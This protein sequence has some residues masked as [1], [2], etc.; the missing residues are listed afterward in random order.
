[1]TPAADAAARREALAPDRSFIVQ[2]PAGS[3][4]TELLTQRYLR[5]LAAVDA[6]E[7]ILAITFTRKAAGEM[8]DRVLRALAAADEAEPDEPH[9][10]RTWQLARAVRERDRERD[11]RL[12]E[13]PARLNIDTLDAYA[14]GLTR[15]LPLTAG[16]GV[17]PRITERAHDV[18]V[19][20]AR[21]T[22]AAL[23]E[24]NGWSDAVAALLAHLDNDAGQLQGLLVAML[25]KR[26]QWLRLIA[27]GH[28]REV[29][30]AALA[31]EVEGQL[32]ALCA[33]VPPAL[34]DDLIMLARRAA[35]NLVH[36]GGDGAQC[37]C[38]ELAELPGAAADDVLLWRGLAA[39]WQTQSGWRKRLTKNEGFPPDQKDFKQQATGL[40]LELGNHPEFA[41]RLASVRSLPPVIYDDAQWLILDALID[42]LKLAAAQLQVVFGEQGSVDFIEIA[43]RALRALGEPDAPTDLALAL[44]YRLQHILV[45]EFQDTSWSQYALLERLT[46]GWSPGDGRTLFLVGDP[47][48]S[49]YRFREAEVGLYL[50]ARREGIGDVHLT[51]LTLGINFRSTAPVVDWINAAFAT[52]F[53]E[54]EDVAAGA[55]PY[56]PAI[57]RDEDARDGGVEVVARLDADDIDEAARV[58]TLIEERRTAAP[59]ETIAV[60]ARSRGQVAATMAALRAAGLKAQAVELEHLA[61]RP[62]VQDL[63][64]LTR[65]LAHP[66]DRLAWLA[67]LRAPWCGLTLADLAA[68]T[69]ND[70]RCIWDLLN[71]GERRGALAVDGRTRLERVAAALAPAVDNWR[72]QPLRRLVEQTWVALSG[73]AC[74]AGPADLDNAEAFFSLLE[75]IDEAGDL[76][77]AG[78]LAERLADLYARPAPD[79]D[80]RLQ[81]MTIHKAKGLEFDTVILPALERL[82]RSDQRQLLLWLERPRAGREPDFLLAPIAAAEAS[83]D[84]LYD[85]LK[86]LRDRQDEL[87]QLRLLYVA[88]TRA[89]RH[90]YLL[91]NIRTRAERNGREIVPP[92]SRSLLM[93]LW[94]AVEAEFATA[95]AAEPIAPAAA[96]LEIEPHPLRRLVADWQPPPAPRIDW[97]VET[98]PGTAA[99][100]VV[101]FSWA[102]ET[103]RQVGVLIHALLER[104]AC[105]GVDGWSDARTAAL[106]PVLESRLRWLG[107]PESDLEP[108]C[109]RIIDAVVTTLGD[110][111]GRWLLAAHDHARSECALSG[112]VDGRRVSGV[113]DRTFLDDQGVRWIVDYKTGGHEGGDVEAFLARERERYAP[114]LGLYARLL[115]A[116]ENRPQRV[117]LY[118]PVL[119]RW[120]EV[121][122]VS[123][124]RTAV[125]DR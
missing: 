7:Q 21:R 47:M 19:E 78:A 5:L 81:V 17:A 20:A 61:D 56:A 3:G 6:P 14:A 72:R 79:A 63:T 92:P 90:L 29:L 34:C 41:T 59:D 106:A 60:L 25:G 31:R 116:R 1:M 93:K 24:R 95:L 124:Q 112:I 121:S 122:E 18:Y 52:L 110:E 115:A 15:R 70:D 2:A 58:V 69:E 120:V 68:L 75:E 99:D 23:E 109:R 48:Q 105:D 111:H 119:G 83:A 117:G 108:A 26:D 42:L 101:E 9:R 4:K 113:I 97:R 87:E 107:V 77:D 38:A 104:I 50:R 35:E 28:E 66:A 98:M 67:V 102:G 45:D 76:S 53:P 82:P 84:A 91:G 22:L 49:I 86:V 36:A 44:D 33:S 51:P 125:S 11:W 40:L 118:F 54:S 32:E 62:V 71:D 27:G 43:L 10:A 88:A 55:V 96:P 73:P 30:E 80:P 13:H 94:P 100:E 39:T 12:A 74:V 37:V 85:G 46:A 65:A 103:A 64:A 123:G 89:R 16:L 57:A 8:R 114:Q